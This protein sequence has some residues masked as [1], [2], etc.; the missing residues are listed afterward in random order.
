MPFPNTVNYNW[1]VSFPG[2]WASENPRRSVLAWANGLRAGTGGVS[3]AAFAWVQADGASVLNTPPSDAA[4]TATASASVAAGGVSAITVTSGGSGYGAV[5]T[6]TLSGGGGT[7]AQATATI[8]NGVVTG[9]TVTAPGTGYTTAPTITLSAPVATPAAP[10]GFVVR[11]Q[12]GL[13]TQYLQEATMT[14]P[15]GFMVTLADGGDVF[16]ACASDA[17]RGDV[18][19][20]SV[21]DGG[22]TA[23]APGT[24]APDGYVATGWRVA[25]PAATGGLIAITKDAS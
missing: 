10:D 2:A 25:L 8:G 12:Q 20:A 21:T 19:C 24:D 13:M 4:A 1:P 14:I 16:C 18:V 5:P 17:A 7:G 6:V 15:Q 23:V 22:I 3:V 9:I 11:E